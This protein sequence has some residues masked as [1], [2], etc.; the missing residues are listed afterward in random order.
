MN[1]RTL[2]ALALGA[3]LLCL[4]A[5]A[6]GGSSATM[7]LTST[8]QNSPMQNGMQASM[9]GRTLPYGAVHGVAIG[10]LHRSAPQRHGWISPAAKGGKLVYFSNLGENSVELFSQQGTNQQPMGTITDGI[11]FPGGL[12]VDNKSNLYVANEGANNVT[13]YPPGSTS[14]SITYTTDLS[15]AADI[16]VAKNGTVYIANFNG[17]ANGWVSVYPKANTAK[18]YRLSDFNGGA[19]LSVAL[20]A[21]QNLYVMYDT[22]GNGGAAVNEYA[23]GAKTGTN[24]NLT[25]QFGAGI[26]VDKSGDVVVVQQVEPSEILVFPPG[27]TTPSQTITLPNSGQPF[28][29]SISK[30]SKALFAGDATHNEALSLAYPAGTLNGIINSSFDNPSGVAVSPAQY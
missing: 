3:S 4:S 1:A 14:P 17:L 21:Q 18:E 11:N 24:L 29:I 27:Q 2:G 9:S 15:T 10:D 6:G 13:V 20:D 19:P 26:Q 5:C 8:A 23:P 25:F 22:N 12:T 7:P 28:A 30:K 16:A